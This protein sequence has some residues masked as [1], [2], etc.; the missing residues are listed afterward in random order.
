MT[1]IND[2]SVIVNATGSAIALLSL[3]PLAFTQ[4]KKAYD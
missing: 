4:W 2:Q 3:I 1:T